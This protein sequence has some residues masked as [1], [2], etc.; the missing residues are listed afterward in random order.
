MK[1]FLPAM[2]SIAC[3]G[4]VNSPA[5]ASLLECS[6]QAAYELTSEPEEER[7]LRMKWNKSE[8]VDCKINPDLRMSPHR[9]MTQQLPWWICGDKTLT[10]FRLHTPQHNTFSLPLSSYIFTKDKSSRHEFIVIDKDK[11][12]IGQKCLLGKTALAFAH[13][14]QSTYAVEN[15][16]LLIKLE[17]TYIEKA[18]AQK[19]SF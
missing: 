8:W 3:I 13:K 9:A 4:A 14:E 16:N 18:K 7:L 19:I 17:Y 6:R 10:I 12:L 15:S 5:Y 11:R 2:A 1:R